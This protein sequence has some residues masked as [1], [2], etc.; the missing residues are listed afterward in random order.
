[1]TDN[2]LPSAEL[3]PALLDHLRTRQEV[4]YSNR[5]AVYQ[6]PVRIDFIDDRDLA[7]TS[8]PTYKYGSKISLSDESVYLLNRLY[9]YYKDYSGVAHLNQWHHVHAMI[10]TYPM[11]QEL[12]DKFEVAL[13]LHVEHEKVRQGKL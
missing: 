4:D 2:H 10:R 12:W 13:A 9:A 5:Y 8:V 7:F 1:M 11:L 3:D 6:Q